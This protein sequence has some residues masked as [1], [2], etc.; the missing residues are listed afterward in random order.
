MRHV[1]QSVRWRLQLWHALI[2]AVVIAIL[3]FFACRIA[4]DEQWQRLYRELDSFEHTLMHRMW[5]HGPEDK[6][7]AEG[8][9]GGPPSMDEFRRRFDALREASDLPQGMRGMFDPSSSDSYYIAVWDGDGQVVFQSANAPA[10]LSVPPGSVAENQEHRVMGGRY[11]EAVHGGPRG[12]RGVVGRDISA[13]LSAL[14]V[15]R[16]KIAGGG[17]VLWLFGLLGGWWLA[18]RAIRPIEDIS[19][20]ASRIAEGDVSE[21]INLTNTDSE[22]GRLSQVLNETFDRLQAAIQRQRQF[23]ADA[24]HELRT[25]LTVILSEVSRGMKRERDADDYREILSNCNHAALRM[26]ALVESLLILA[27]QDGNHVT[28]AE[29]KHDLAS[30][31]SDACRLLQPLAGQCGTEMTLD[32]KTA[33]FVGDGS[34]VSMVAI[35]LI[36]NAIDHQGPGGK[37]S[38]ATQEEDGSA[39]LVVSDTGPGIAEKH[40]PHLFDRFYRIDAARGQASGHSGLGLAIAKAIVDNHGGSIEVESEVGKGTTFRVRLPRE[41]HENV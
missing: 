16:W 3:C 6:D 38:V 8:K 26:R 15:A 30:L 41:I 11:L 32:L 1:F 28:A 35:N 17:A 5:D 25:P 19:R 21:R 29:A 27:R 31:A 2:L 20:T 18:G 39:V 9:P 22:L 24:S 13:D 33:S 37:V 7:K 40:L 12:S 23:T 36:S 34:A 14:Q 10:H 4:A